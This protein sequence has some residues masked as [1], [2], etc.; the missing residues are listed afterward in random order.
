MTALL[1]HSHSPGS[2]E[3]VAVASRMLVVF[4]P[5]IALYGLAVVIYGILQSHH[6]FTAPALA[7]L[8]S[9]LVVSAAYLAFLPI[10]NGYQNHLHGLPTPRS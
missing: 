1:G 2:A 9:S 5:Q 4:A 3:I 10:G 6:R 7:P 8:V